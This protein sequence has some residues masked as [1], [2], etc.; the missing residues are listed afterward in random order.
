L[1]EYSLDSFSHSEQTLLAHHIQK[2]NLSIDKIAMESGSLSHW[3][4]TSV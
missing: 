3:F 2:Q 4:K 1:T